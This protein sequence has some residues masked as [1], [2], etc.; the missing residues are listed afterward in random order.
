MLD[1]F[2]ILSIDTL[3]GT[4][5]CN[6][7]EAAALISKLEIGGGGEGEK[8]L[9]P[10]WCRWHLQDVAGL[11]CLFTRSAGYCQI[12]FCITVSLVKITEEYYQART[13]VSWYFLW[14]MTDD[15]CLHSRSTRVSLAQHNS[16]IQFNCNYS[17]CTSLVLRC[18]T[19][20]VLQAAASSAAAAAG[21]DSEPGAPTPDVGAIIPPGRAPFPS[22]PGAKTR[23]HLGGSVCQIQ[24]LLCSSSGTL[25]VFLLLCSPFYLFIF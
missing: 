2:C 7:I 17:L 11:L 23:G 13:R 6:E 22:T 14:I 18:Q 3:G 16:K 8:K 1:V 24:V 10:R 12:F 21:K 20:W 9:D 25:G 19:F 5:I 4:E 15:T